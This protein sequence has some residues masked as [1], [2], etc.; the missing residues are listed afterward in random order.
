MRE[1]KLKTVVFVLL[2]ASVSLS[3]AQNQK[4]N[5]A[6]V[7]AWST[8]VHNQPP[9][10]GLPPAPVFENRTVRM[11]VRPTLSGQQVRVR[12]SNAYGSSP[13]EI[14]SAHLALTDH[15]AAILP[16]SDR[17]I[18]FGGKPSV[19]VPPG[20]PILSDPV[21]MKMQ[22]FKEF[23]ISVYLPHTA[24]E[25]T[26]HLWAQHATYVSGAG[27]FSAKTD[28][29]DAVTRTSWF[30]LADVE[31]LTSDRAAAIVTLGDSI[32]D[33]VGA[34]QGSYADWP[35]Q[36]AKRLADAGMTQLAVLN[37]GIGGNRILH[38]GAGINTLARLDRDV[39][40][41]PAV[42]S[43]IVL[44]GINDI[45]WPHMKMP[46]TSD[47]A[48]PKENPLM[49]Q[50]VTAQDLIDGYKQIIDRAHQHHIKVF[51][52]TLTPYEGAGYFSADGEAVRQAVNQ[53]IRTSGMFDGVFDFDAAVRDPD[54]PSRFRDG[55]HSGDNLH[56]SA[57]GYKA[58]ANAIDIGSL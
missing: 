18:T 56:P 44:E 51:G 40:A 53:W 45:G 6:W 34:Q 11:V 35:D 58:M 57:V 55:F 42:R 4:L 31:V 52:A 48:P 46:S 8:A 15:D 5:G 41:Q 23:S 54:H 3:A 14:G 36:L 22:A 20:A 24:P 37:E 7:S 28:I 1:R 2:M 32:T 38:D 12:F 29:P 39:L 47:A 16:E 9:F 50:I 27:D 13:L 19:M 49:A 26:T 10:P 43:V 17:A 33:G 25:L 30:F 21:D